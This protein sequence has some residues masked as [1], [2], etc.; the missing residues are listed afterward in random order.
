MNEE[1]EKLVE[2]GYLGPFSLSGI[3]LAHLTDTIDQHIMHLA[4]PNQNYSRDLDQRPWFK[5]FHSLAPEF[6]DLARHPDL[7]KI[8][9]NSFP[10]RPTKL[11]GVAPLVKQ[12]GAVHRWHSD[13]ETRCWPTLTAWVG[14][15]GV[16]ESASLQLI[17]HTHK[18][19]V[20]PD[21]LRKQGQPME[22][23]AQVLSA[24][25]AL[26]PACELI[27][28]DMK[29]GD[30]IMFLGAMWHGTHNT[31]SDTRYAV[32]LQYSDAD[33]DVRVPMNFEKPVLWHT[34]EP[35]CYSA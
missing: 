17:S 9:H 29:D 19:S 21:V 4:W 35:R 12:A 28:P 15:K 10:G 16:S 23:S 2:L 30:C 22:T 20:T 32:T 26:N 11:W 18:L 13:I 24:A 6:V 1:A 31:S 27:I 3:D 5:S 34:Q 25:R 14:L 8:V 7:L 33:A